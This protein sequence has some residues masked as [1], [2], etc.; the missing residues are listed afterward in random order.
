VCQVPI[1]GSAADNI[2]NNVVESKRH[3]QEYG[4]VFGEQT[5]RLSGLVERV[6]LLPPRARGSSV[7]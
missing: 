7:M 4:W 5:R 3:L 6:L 1:I 2:A